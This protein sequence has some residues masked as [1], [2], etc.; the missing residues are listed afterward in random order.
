MNKNFNTY[1]INV[2]INTDRLEFMTGQ[3]DNLKIS[4]E[5]FYGIYGVEHDFTGIYDD[6]LSKKVNGRSMNKGEQGC[7]LSHKICIEKI[8]NG[9]ENYGLIL[10]DDVQM[11][12]NFKEVI[13]KEIEKNKKNKKWDYLLFDYPEPGV[14]FIKHWVSTII[15][16][17]RKNNFSIVKSFN[18]ISYSILKSFYIIPLSLLEGARNYMYKTFK[19]G[20]PVKFLRPLYFAGAYLI[21]KEGAR[22]LLDVNKKLVYPADKLPNIAKNKTNLKFYGYSPISVFQK[23][24][25]FISGIHND[26]AY[27]K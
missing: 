15:L 5:T 13:E 8:L 10:E 6:E 3:L 25:A 21:S 27:K 18:F 2:K 16:N 17:Y 14:Y 23:R 7:A 24:S 19:I 12:E 4:F 9:K 11:P 1:V 20:G 26:S 22:K